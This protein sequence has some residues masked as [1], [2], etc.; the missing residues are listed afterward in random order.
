MG[1]SETGKRLADML[2]EISDDRAF[3]MGVMGSS[4]NDEAWSK[5]IDFITIAK[6]RGDKISTDDLLLL[7]YK[8]GKERIV[9]EGN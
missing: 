4:P 7:S 5:I 1:L 2:I 8:I 3:I 9:N 6:R